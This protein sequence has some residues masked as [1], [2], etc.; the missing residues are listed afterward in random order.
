MIEELDNIRSNIGSNTLKN[1]KSLPKEKAYQFIHDPKWIANNPISIKDENEFNIFKQNLE[2]DHAD[3]KLKV[4]NQQA[5]DII[6][7]NITDTY[8]KNLK[9]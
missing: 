8:G 4:G 1:L 2:K 9:I 3:G 5:Q 7:A 6:T